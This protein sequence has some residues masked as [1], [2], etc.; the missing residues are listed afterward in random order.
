MTFGA[1]LADPALAFPIVLSIKIAL[2]TFAI[3]ALAGPLLGWALARP[4]WFGRGLI[5]VLVTLPMVFP[6]IVLGFFLLMLL[7][8]GGAMGQW[9]QA[10]FDFSFIFTTWG[11]L[12]A[13]VVVGLPLVVKPVAAAIAA[14]PPNLAEAARTLGHSEVSIF[15]HVLLPNIRGVIA[16]GLLLAAARSLGEVGVTL[17]LGGN[18]AGQTNTISL[19]IY[20]AV[21]QGEFQR[22]TV[23]SVLLGGFSV[24]VIGALRLW[25]KERA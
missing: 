16:A 17:M 22:A 18:I 6:P 15:L 23:L 4:A 21:I 8:R 20:N 1:V 10:W 25:G 14:L 3:H 11:V 13:S 9:L 12:L 19:E 5:D 24:I 2:G 7:G